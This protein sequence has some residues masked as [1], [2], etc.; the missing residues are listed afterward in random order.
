MSCVFSSSGWACCHFHFAR[1]E[2]IRLR[3][4]LRVDETRH[5]ANANDVD[6]RPFRYAAGLR[7]N[8]TTQKSIEK[9]SRR[10][11]GTFGGII[12]EP[13][14]ITPIRSPILG[15]TVLARVGWVSEVNPDSPRHAT[16]RRT[17]SR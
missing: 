2:P 8:A 15:T 14:F 16:W 4:S 6:A 5:H 1:S 7:A 11:G 12:L 10:D 17:A 3:A 13:N 9:D